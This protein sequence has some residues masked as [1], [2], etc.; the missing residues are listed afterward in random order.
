MPNESV[1][2]QWDDGKTVTQKQLASILGVSVRQVRRYLTD[3]EAPTDS[4]DAF[5]H[6][7]FT[8]DLIVDVGSDYENMTVNQLKIAKM[9]HDT[10]KAEHEARRSEI[11]AEREQFDFDVHK[12]D[13]VEK[14]VIVMN[15]GNVSVALRELLFAFPDK[16]ASRIM[17][18]ESLA[19]PVEVINAALR[20]ITE[21]IDGWEIIPEGDNESENTNAPDTDNS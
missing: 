14:S 12:G 13:F 17:G 4:L 2:F 16:V 9:R 6:W 3:P 19:E 21:E 11:G 7:R 8:K 20:D 15:M 1:R 18:C 10:R 5:V